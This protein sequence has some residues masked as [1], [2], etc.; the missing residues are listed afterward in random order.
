MLM[1]LAACGGDGNN[2]HPIPSWPNATDSVNRTYNL[3][4]QKE[5][6]IRTSNSRHSIQQLNRYMVEVSGDDNMIDFAKS[7][8]VRKLE[9]TGHRNKIEIDRDAQIDELIISGND[10]AFRLQPGMSI[11]KLIVTGNNATIWIPS[12][13]ALTRSEGNGGNLVIAT[14]AP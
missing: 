7:Q 8:T 3:T 10:N 2:S 5:I 6:K 13:Y 9:V 14:F 12:G 4:W 11:R 1:T